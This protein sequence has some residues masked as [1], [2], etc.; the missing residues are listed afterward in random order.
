MSDTIDTSETT[1]EADFEA[2]PVGKRRWPWIVVGIVVVAL[3][4]AALAFVFTGSEAPEEELALSTATVERS[5]LI[6]ME[7]LSGTLGYGSADA[8]SY[9][10]SPDGI[11]T[12]E[13]LKA[14]FVTD[15]SDPEV[16]IESGDVLYEVNTEPVVVLDGDVPAYRTFESRMSDGS[17]VEQLEQALVDLGFDPDNDIEIDEDFT[18]ATADAIELLQAAI[19]A[20]ETGRLLLGDV[21]FAPMPSFISEMLVE[22][23]DQVQAGMS[24]A[25]ASKALS[26]TATWVTEE[27]SL[28][29][30]GE[31]LFAID[32]EAVVLLV[33]D[34]PLYRTLRQGMQGEDVAQLQ[35]SLLDLGFGTDESLAIT[36]EFDD[37]TVLSVAAWQAASGAVPDGV[38]NI[39]DV[40]IQPST[41]RVNET[42]ISVGDAVGP[43]T[44]LLTASV[45]D[46]FVTVEL[47][48]DDQDLVAVGDAVI[49]EL[50]SGS[51]EPAVVTE[52]GSVVLATQ[53][54]ETYFE[55]TV[56][57][58]SPDAAQGLDRAPVDVEVIGDRA[59]D[60][61]VVPVTSLLALAEGGYAVEV[62]ASD[63]STVL[64]A[65]DPGLFADGFV[66]VSSGTLEAGMQ[67][68]VP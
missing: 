26:G 63:G 65:A 62:V 59:D 51:Q 1:S 37:A 16:I 14:G 58:D 34:I 64:V 50:P 24:I 55:M 67:V 18:A 3:T 23:G 32:G 60:V 47:S 49:V 57:L 28:I 56:T 6:A 31:T 9:Q 45:S 11:V 46:T 4:A 40:V 52:I 61:L 48:T 19:G 25:A 35:Q 15:V 20:A 7:T 44:M 2:E 12:V 42:L 8:I 13:G 36:G 38:V 21:I 53:Q 41:I 22:I 39:G 43:G 66:E 27:G 10:S 68:V 5:N 30:A 33:G 29:A 54:G 17:D